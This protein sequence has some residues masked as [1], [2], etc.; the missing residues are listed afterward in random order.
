MA[1]RYQLRQ[2]IPGRA[3]ILVADGTDELQSAHAIASSAYHHYERLGL[4]A[5]Q[6]GHRSLGPCRH[7]WIRR[8]NKDGKVEPA[9]HKLNSQERESDNRA[10]AAQKKSVQAV[11][12]DQ[13]AV[14]C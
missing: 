9:Q 3:T 5:G 14:E 10:P 8:Q 1:R 6:S 7:E 2:E 13:K 12:K 4:G 11:A